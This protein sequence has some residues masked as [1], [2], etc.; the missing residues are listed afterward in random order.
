MPSLSLRLPTAFL[1]VALAAA[2]PALADDL[3]PFAAAIDANPDD[4]KAY[5]AY[6]VAAISKNRLD[7]AIAKVKQGVARVP[8]FARGYYLLAYAYRKKQAWADAADYYRVYI[9]LRPNEVDPWFGL[10]KSL[11]GLGDKR[12]AVAALKRYVSLEKRPQSQRYVEEAQQEIARLEPPA[13]PPADPAALKAEAE[14]LRNEGK[15]DEAVAAY[16]RAIEADR[17]NLELYSELGSI[18]T[19]LKRYDQA[20]ALFKQLTER[21]PNYAYAW[22]NLA[23]ANRKLERW[24]DAADGYRHYMAL[25]PEDP[26]PYYGLGYAL[27]GLGDF[28]GALSA[29]R[30]YVD[31]EKRPSE[32]KWVERARQELSEL[33]AKV[34]PPSEPGKFMDEKSSLQG[35]PGAEQ[36]PLKRDPD[37]LLAPEQ[38]LERPPRLRDLHDPFQD[39]PFDDRTRVYPDGLIN[40]FALPPPLELHS[41]RLTH[42]RAYGQAVAA[43]RRALAAQVEDVST[44]YERGVAHAL[45]GRARDAV[46]SWDTI[47]LEDGRVVQAKRTIEKIRSVR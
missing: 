31:M 9:A 23:Y 2:R 7:D 11:V 35:M 5:E 28:N 13:A 33:E 26:D 30:K 43:Y 16:K 8:D 3:D 38:M 14:R 25:K 41:P 22:F 39:A 46:S 12:G 19:H 4:A 10:G 18:Y 32:Q 44:R 29:F 21:D 20:A 24:K 15:L 42:A 36:A 17:N 37:E 27:K 47:T 34:R 1:L 40:P 6:A 45:A